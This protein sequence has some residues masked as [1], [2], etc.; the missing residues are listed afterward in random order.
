MSAM[1]MTS[2]LLPICAKCHASK[3]SGNSYLDE[4]WRYGSQDH[5][6]H[7]EECHSYVPVRTLNTQRWLRRTGVFER[8]PGITKFENLLIE[9]LMTT[10]EFAEPSGPWYWSIDISNGASVSWVVQ[11]LSESWSNDCLSVVCHLFSPQ[12]PNSGRKI[13]LKI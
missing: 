9:S 12:M 11:S 1:K 13:S 8:I 2:S 10:E 5:N 6:F 4:Y 3:Y 7:Q